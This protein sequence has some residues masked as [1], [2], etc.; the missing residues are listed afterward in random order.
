MLVAKFK[1]ATI[2]LKQSESVS[3]SVVFDSLHPQR[4]EPTRLLSPW[5]SPGKNTV[6]GGHSLLQG[7]FPTQGLNPGLLHCRQ[8]LDCLSQQGSPM[9]GFALKQIEGQSQAVNL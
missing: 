3:V 6:V 5:D 9:M 8:I 2:Y 1:H 4:L 7:T